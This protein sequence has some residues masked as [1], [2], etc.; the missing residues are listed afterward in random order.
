MKLNKK[1]S[2]LFLISLILFFALSTLILP[3]IAHTN[4]EMFLYNAL[5]VSIPALLLPALV[6]R[7]VNRFPVF[8]AP[9]FTHILL[10]LVLGFGCLQLNQ[11]LYCLNETIFFGIEID[12]AATTAESLLDMSVLNMVLSLGVIPP[13]SEEFLMR[14]ALLETW[15]RYSPIGAAVLT[16]LLFALMHL[17]PSAFI[18]YFGIGLLFAAVYLITRNVWLTVIVHLVNNMAS[19]LTAISM[20]NSAG[21]LEAADESA[22]AIT[23][24]FATRGGNF[25]MF[26]IYAALAALFIVPAIL[27]LKNSCEKRGIGMYAPP[28]TPAVPE[29]EA[30][31]EAPAEGEAALVAPAE[32][33]GSMWRD[34]VLWT[35]IAVL[36]ILNVIMGLSEFGV[37]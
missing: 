17:A 28:E 10:A 29:D 22:E 18:V 33:K 9:R 7:R 1:A 26:I 35:T 16:S 2:L 24:I 25:E 30:V 19:V 32:V 21:L 8:R 27:G 37:I 34:A 20:K 14:G 4:A 13:L 23:D 5:L 6:Y 3:H 15:R 12:S 31:S 36:V 11:A